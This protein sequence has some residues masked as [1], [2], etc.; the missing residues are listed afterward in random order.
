MVK[1]FD[2]VWSVE[3]SFKQVVTLVRREWPMPNAG[4]TVVS[5]NN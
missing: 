4:G 5:E 3:D 2:I 1:D